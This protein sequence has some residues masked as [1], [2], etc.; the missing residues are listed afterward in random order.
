MTFLSD[1]QPPV[2]VE[3]WER[4]GFSVVNLQMILRAMILC[5]CAVIYTNPKDRCVLLKV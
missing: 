1:L 3:L 5:S 4:Q 2:P